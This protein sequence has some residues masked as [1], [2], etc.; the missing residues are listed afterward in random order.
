MFAKRPMNNEFQRF[1]PGECERTLP[2]TDENFYRRR[3]GSSEFHYKCKS[4]MR[5]VTKFQSKQR[6]DRAR[7]KRL[8]QKEMRYESH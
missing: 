5:A 8:K 7:A 6:R 4:C 1:C 2:L 3:V